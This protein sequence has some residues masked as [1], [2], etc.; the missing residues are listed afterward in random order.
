VNN[1]RAAWGPVSSLL[2]ARRYAVNYTG[3]LVKALRTVLD[4][5]LWR[6]FVF[7]GTGEIKSF[8]TFAEFLEWGDTTPSELLAVLRA[9]DEDELAARVLGM[10]TTAAAKHGANQHRDSGVGVT[11]CTEENDAAYVVARLKRDD[12]A[13]AAQVVSGT[14]TPNAAAIQ[15]GIR[16]KYARVRTDDALRAVSV[17]L[18]CYTRE[19]LLTAL[20][21]V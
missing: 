8:G 16:H 7:M 1:P 14:I 5:E 3:T 17:L 13:L 9:R 19:Q 15:A 21:T 2:S 6:E 12:P 18:R 10:M 11:N 20:E 4:E